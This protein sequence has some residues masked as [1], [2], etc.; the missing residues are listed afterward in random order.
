MSSY[1]EAIAVPSTSYIPEGTVVD[2]TSYDAPS[3]PPMVSSQHTSLRYLREA[4]NSFY[5]PDV[6]STVNQAAAREFLTRMRWPPGLQDFLIH[7]VSSKLPYRFFICDDSG[8]MQTSDG[9]RLYNTQGGL[10]KIVSCSRWAE[11]SDSLRFHVSLASALNVHAEFRL[12]NNAA[13]IVVGGAESKPE[14][15]ELM[16][17]ILDGSPC[18]LIFKFTD[19]FVFFLYYLI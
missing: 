19:I 11:L 8:S 9:K 5:N 14:N 15:A 6:S 13:P 7:N 17:A 2:V 16:N 18:T 12:L 3:A 1:P 10:P 4:N